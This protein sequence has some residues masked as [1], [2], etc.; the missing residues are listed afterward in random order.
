MNRTLFITATIFLLAVAAGTLDR[1]AYPGPRGLAASPPLLSVAGTVLDSDGKAVAGAAVYLREW[2]FL[3][4][5]QPA[6]ETGDSD[7]LATT[8]TDAKG[9]FSFRDV[10]PKKPSI[11][12]P[13]GPLVA[14]WDVIAIA[15]GYGLA[16]ERL[17]ARDPHPPLQLTLSP[18]ARITGQLLDAEKKPVDGV[19]VQ[20]VAIQ[21]L[22]RPV[23]I[24]YS[25]TGYLSLHRSGVPIATRSDAGG[26]FVLPGLLG[27]RRVAFEVVD[28]RF[29]RQTFYAATTD[30]PQPDVVL[31]RVFSPEGGVTV[32]RQPVHTGAFSLTLQPAHQLRVRVFFEGTG[33]PAAGALLRDMEGPTPLPQAKAVDPKGMLVL[34]QLAAGRYTLTIAA[35]GQSDYLGKTV[36]VD[37]PR[38][39][40][41]LDMRVKLSAGSVVTGQVIEEESGKGIPEVLLAHQ[42][43][44]PQSNENQSFTSPVRTG[45]DGSFRLA[46]RPAR[47]GSASLPRWPAM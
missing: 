18:E 29:A 32:Q 43:L 45:P 13:T 27:D 5:S 42:P 37:I 31:G 26:R 23:R 41:E 11:A 39:K 3:R 2:A 38:D 28:Q 46:S 4:K 35:P 10:S 15:K 6:E 19:R 30:Q 40:P 44:I 1:R 33:K 17:E 24:P 36:Q 14:P 16:W 7:I 34:G 9:Q 22:N 25:T 47:A 20:A 21:S 8:T 12:E